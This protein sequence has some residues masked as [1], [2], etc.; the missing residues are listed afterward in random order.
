MSTSEPSA[1]AQYRANGY[2]IWRDA[3]DACLM[4]EANRFVNWTLAHNP[5]TRPENLNSPLTRHEPFLLRLVSDDRLLDLASEFLGPDIALYGAHFLCKPPRDGKSVAW[6]QDGGYWPLEPMEALTLWVAITASTQANGCMRVIPGTHRLP[7]Q[8]RQEVES[9]E[10]E[11][12]AGMDQSMVDET[13]AVDLELQPGDVSAHDVTIVHGSRANH[14]SQW[15]NA[16]AIRYIASSTRV[17]DQS[18]G[19]QFLLRGSPG[20]GTNKYLPWPSFQP[21]L[22]MPFKGCETWEQGGA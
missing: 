21:D 7:M 1:V 15:R 20:P 16:V 11:M 14:S 3:L 5:D 22:H 17:L 8:S 19:S 12:L 6:H 9:K 4:E 18:H 13:Q 2:T 10:G